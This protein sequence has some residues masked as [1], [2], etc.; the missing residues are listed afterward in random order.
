MIYFERFN[1]QWPIFQINTVMKASVREAGAAT[2]EPRLKVWSCIRCPEKQL[3]D[4]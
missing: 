1:F 3:L 2:K 4:F